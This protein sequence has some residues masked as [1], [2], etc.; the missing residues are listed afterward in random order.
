MCNNSDDSVTTYKKVLKLKFSMQQENEQTRDYLKRT[1]RRHGFS[2]V[3]HI[4][5]LRIL[6]KFFE[7]R[8]FNV[9]V[10][11]KI[12]FSK[13]VI[14]NQFDIRFLN[15]EDIKSYFG[16]GFNDITPEQ[17]RDLIL[18]QVD[19]LCV[20]EKKSGKISAYSWFT[21]HSISTG[22][23]DLEIQFN[24][25]YIYTLKVYTVPEFRGLNLHA[26]QM[27][28]ALSRYQQ[29]GYLGI[30]GYTYSDNF[31]SIKSN[32]KM[33]SEVIGHF[34]VF[35]IFNSVFYLRFGQLAKYKVSLQKRS[36]E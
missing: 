29:K 28:Y 11:C 6:N 24:Q 8:I 18:K 26:R 36:Y 9:F 4:I 27:Q 3:L 2:G 23:Y 17:T 22:N 15:T 7:F 35:K 34:W 21:S 20:F 10:I 16:S 14:E 12:S 32:A 31:D 5:F 30:L 25:R 13:P 33:G 19:C 1:Y